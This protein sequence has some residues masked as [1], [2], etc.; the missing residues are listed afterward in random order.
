V[1][2]N[3]GYV[4]DNKLKSTEVNYIQRYMRCMNEAR[5]PTALR[6]PPCSP[7]LI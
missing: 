7:H 6:P 5:L 1:R 3:C 2:S 4:R